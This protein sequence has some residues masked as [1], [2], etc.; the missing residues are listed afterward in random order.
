MRGFNEKLFG[1][2]LVA[3]QLPTQLGLIG[4]QEVIDFVGLLD[5]YPNAAAAYS[6]R[7][8]RAAYTGSSIRVRRSSDNTESDIGFSNGDLD[9]SALTSF[10]GSGNGFVTTW[11]DQSG[12]ARNATQSTAGNQPQIVS[13][14]SIITENGK[15]TLQFDGSND[16]LSSIFG[17]TITSPVTYLASFKLLSLQNA[18]KN[19]YSDRRDLI[20]TYLQT[21]NS[22][23]L[24]NG[25][26]LGS[27][28]IAQTINYLNYTMFNGTSDVLY[29]NNSLFINGDASPGTVSINS[30]DI[31]GVST[32]SNRNINV[33]YYELIVYTENQNTNRT[34]LQ[35]NINSYYGIY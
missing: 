17:T 4:S 13:S 2:K 35:N 31:G 16:I 26:A 19:I 32:V 24:W 34:G 25:S 3:G 1:D 5:Y 18:L 7:K 8:L 14:G 10:C 6:V 11:Y 9:T 23:N 33:K 20:T 30:V 29:M 27:S 21:N 28:F 12:N 22:W 15:P